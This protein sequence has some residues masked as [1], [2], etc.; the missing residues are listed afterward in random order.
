MEQILINAYGYS[1]L[2]VAVLAHFY[3]DQLA[4]EP[5]PVN[6]LYGF[7][8]DIRRHLEST[9]FPP[10]DP[11]REKIRAVALAGAEEFFR[12]VRD[13]LVRRNVIELKDCA[14]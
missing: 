14:L 13:I 10:N 9:V 4:Q 11:D 12:Q 5:N 7:R 2:Q 6:G 3:A 8:N 1:N